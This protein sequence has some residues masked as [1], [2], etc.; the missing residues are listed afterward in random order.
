MQLSGEVFGNSLGVHTGPTAPVA[1]HF[2]Q[3]VSPYVRARVWQIWS[4]PAMIGP[5]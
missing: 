3:Q 4:R 1:I 2:S 5:C